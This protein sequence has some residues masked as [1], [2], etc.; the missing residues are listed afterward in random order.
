MSLPVRKNSLIWLESG[1]QPLLCLAFS[2]GAVDYDKQ[3]IAVIYA[4]KEEP[5]NPNLQNKAYPEKIEGSLLISLFKR[6]ALNGLYGERDIDIPFG[7]DTRIIVAENGY[8]KTTV[9]NALYALVT[10]D[11]P[12]LHKIDFKS[13]ELEFSDGAIFKIEKPELDFSFNEDA[14]S[15]ASKYL[16]A[17]LGRES[18]EKLIQGFITYGEGHTRRSELFHRVTQTIGLSPSHTIRVI[19]ALAE[20]NEASGYLLNIKETLEA[21]KAKIPFDVLYLPTYRRV[22]QDLRNLS[23]DEEKGD[24]AFLNQAI[25]FGMGDVDAR[26]KQI[27]KEILSSSVEWFSKVNGQML[28]QLVDGLIIEQHMLDS[29]QS[30]AAVKIVLDRVGN[31][32]STSSKERILELIKTKDI[33]KGHDHLIYFIS[34]LVKVYEQQRENDTALQEFCAV[35][36]KYL[37]DK[38]LRYDESKVEVDIVRKKNL[39]DVKIETLSSGEKQIT[40]LFSRLYLH[41]Q[42]NLGIFFDEPE[43]S[44]SIEWQKTLL[45]D[46][47]NSGKCSFLFATTH[48]PF[49]FHNK[50]K[51]QTVDLSSFIKEL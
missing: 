15:Q 31:N 35:C 26:I 25:N 36:N 34:S 27:T 37:G 38:M 2:N 47:L 21:I 28:N 19:R 3:L 49:I 50:L 44:L 8:G 40:S 43:L 48:S 7:T 23:S 51:S 45:P 13:M 33:T 1:I 6:F 4:K 9:L 32:I 24:K 39:R 17:K 41:K 18:M 42:D 46:I 20:A 5:D 30:P 12:R 16:Y 29:I 10:S 14:D 11:I 22:E